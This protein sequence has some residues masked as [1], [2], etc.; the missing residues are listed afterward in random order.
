VLFALQ[1]GLLSKW[2]EVFPD[3]AKEPEIGREILFASQ[4]ASPFCR[5]V[6]DAQAGY[7]LR[8]ARVGALGSRVEYENRSRAYRFVAPRMTSAS[9]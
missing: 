9:R 2:A 8:S 3:H 1:S 5:T 4:L 6:F 7:V